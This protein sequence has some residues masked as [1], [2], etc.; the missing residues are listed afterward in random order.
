MKYV[1]KSTVRSVNNSDPKPTTGELLLF[2]MKQ[3]NN[4]SNQAALTEIR[5][6]TTMSTNTSLSKSPRLPRLTPWPGQMNFACTQ[7]VDTFKIFSI[8]GETKYQLR[9]HSCGLATRP[10][11]N[12]GCQVSCIS[13]YMSHKSLTAL[14]C[15]PTSA[16]MHRTS[17]GPGKLTAPPAQEKL[18]QQFLR[19]EEMHLQRSEL[20]THLNSNNSYKDY[21]TIRMGVLPKTR[22]SWLQAATH[23]PHNKNKPQQIH[24]LL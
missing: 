10:L 3:C 18:P 9:E 14:S 19:A 22:L 6:P 12:W 21:T 2:W 1:C 15:H 20:C 24:T 5:A 13:R 8:E 7:K 17:W 16:E 23:F 11:S 4:K